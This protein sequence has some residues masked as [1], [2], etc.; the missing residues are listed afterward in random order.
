MLQVL[1]DTFGSE[2]GI[3]IVEHNLDRRLPHL[4]SFDAVVSSFAIHH[5]P[6]NRKRALYREIFDL[7]HPGGAFLNLEH[8]ASSTASLHRQY[9][10]TLDITPETEDPSNKLLEVGTQLRWL[11]QIGFVDVDCHW[12]WRELALLAGVKPVRTSRRRRHRA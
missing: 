10:Q 9:L 3:A 7:L 8:V 5:L 6:H 1:R 2:P 4:G 11:H 12:K